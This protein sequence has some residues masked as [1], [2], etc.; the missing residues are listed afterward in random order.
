[1]LMTE[2][3]Y[4]DRPAPAIEPKKEVIKEVVDN[5]SSS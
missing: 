5:G 2:K 1:M 4:T 3:E